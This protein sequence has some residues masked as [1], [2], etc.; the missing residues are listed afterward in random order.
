MPKSAQD[1]INQYREVLNPNK[2]Q[3][4]YRRL[5]DSKKVNEN[6]PDQ[7][8]RLS[9][10]LVVA[11]QNV[12]IPGD[13]RA[14]LADQQQALETLTSQ[15]VSDQ[16]DMNEIENALNTLG[17]LGDLL[18]E[19]HGPDGRTVY[20]DVVSTNQSMGL[21]Q[22][23]LDDNLNVLS[24]NLHLG[25]DTQRLHDHQPMVHEVWENEAISTGWSLRKFY[26][27]HKL[28]DRYIDS[29]EQVCKNTTFILLP[30]SEQTENIEKTLSLV[31]GIVITG[32]A[33]LDGK[34]FNQET[35]PTCDDLEP[36]R[37]TLFNLEVVNYAIKHNK[38]VFGIC[39]GMQI[40]NV[41]RGGDLIQDI[42]SIIDSKV[43]HNGI[44]ATKIAHNLN[45]VKRDSFIYKTL[46][47]DI[48]DVN[49]RHHQA[50]GKIGEG[51]SITSI[52]E[53]GIIESIECDK[54]VKPIIGVQWHPE[55]LNT[56]DDKKIIK[57]FCD[58]I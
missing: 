44:I 13:F 38:G 32:G 25:I 58:S 15:I 8:T 22:D 6:L 55:F 52:A 11:L 54:C 51:L 16:P 18:A 45:I 27:Y 49:S 2:N 43:S 1:L 48:I 19:S 37:R 40:I 57:A 14:R 7:L 10:S 50:V 46:K 53:D 4:E 5:P 12:N 41:A 56:E 29:F 23:R 24:T 3:V 35:H 30:I 20:D 33:D 36:D 17:G 26:N 31:D 21:G 34:F 47:K 42:P 9:Q 39:N 28:R